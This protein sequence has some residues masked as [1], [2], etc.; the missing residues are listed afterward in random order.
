MQH[1]SYPTFDMDAP[2]A[3][4]TASARLRGNLLARPGARR[5]VARGIVQAAG[6]VTDSARQ[7]LEIRDAARAVEHAAKTLDDVISE[8]DARESSSAPGPRRGDP[9]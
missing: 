1:R 5:E 4:L 9:A 2:A 8:Q 3:F 7:P 6:V